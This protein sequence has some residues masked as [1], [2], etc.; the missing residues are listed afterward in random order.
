MAGFVDEWYYSSRTL[1]SAVGLTCV[2]FIFI[3]LSFGTPYW[4]Q[5]VPDEQLPH[6]KFTN[7]G[8]RQ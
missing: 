8:K 2:T 7:L 5:S 1:K 3:E 4:L 6:P